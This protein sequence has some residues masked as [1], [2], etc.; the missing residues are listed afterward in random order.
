MEEFEF[1]GFLFNAILR[2]APVWAAA[3]LSGIV[4]GAVHGSISAFVPLACSGVVLAYVYYV[5]G[6][7]TASAIAHAL[8]N[9]INVALLSISKT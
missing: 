8:F 9:L 1:R 4:F 6:S 5:S 7:L 2:Y 3:I